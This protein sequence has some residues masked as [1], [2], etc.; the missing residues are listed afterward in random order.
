MWRIRRVALHGVF[1]A[2]FSV[3]LCLSVVFS[4]WFSVA[5]RGILLLAG[6]SVA[7]HCVVFLALFSVVL[8]PQSTSA[9]LYPYLQGEQSVAPVARSVF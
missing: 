3:A 9:P 7:L 6:F 5:L 2:W 4:A 8:L 1:L